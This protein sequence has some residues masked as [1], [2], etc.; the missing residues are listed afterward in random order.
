MLRAQDLFVNL[1][2][3]LK[4]G[5]G[6]RVLALG[7]V[8]RRQAVQ[9]LRHGRMVGAGMSLLQLAQLAPPANSYTDERFEIKWLLQRGEKRVQRGKV[10]QN[11]MVPVERDRP[12]LVVGSERWWEAVGEFQNPRLFLVIAQD[13]IKVLASH[14]TILCLGRLI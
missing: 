4:E 11:V 9:T 13:H 2:R 6:L 3:P 12:P 7:L 1:E 5:L 8:K 14:G 10:E